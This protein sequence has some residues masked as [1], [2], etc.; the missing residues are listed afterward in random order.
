MASL[1]SLRH[2]SM[3]HT[4]KRFTNHSARNRKTSTLFDCIAYR[5]QHLKI[6]G[7]VSAHTLQFCRLTGENRVADV[8]LQQQQ[9][10]QQ[11][12][13][14]QLS[15]DCR[16]EE[17]TVLV[18]DGTMNQ[19]VWCVKLFS[20]FTFTTILFSQPILWGK[21]AALNNFIHQVCIF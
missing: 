4:L 12:Q 11:Q 3:R 21:L 20:L 15:N 16:L 8:P 18:Y 14:R 9:Q 1:A 19:L 6:F 2:I 17:A 13:Q 7:K 10:Q 5:Q